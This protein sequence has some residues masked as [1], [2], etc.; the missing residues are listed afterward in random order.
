MTATYGFFAARQVNVD[1]HI[2]DFIA[3]RLAYGLPW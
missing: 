2:S 1:D 3:G